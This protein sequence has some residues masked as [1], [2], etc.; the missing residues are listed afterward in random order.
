MPPSRLTFIVALVASMASISD[1]SDLSST[2]ARTAAAV[3]ISKHIEMTVSRDRVLRPAREALAAAERKKQLG[4]DGFRKGDFLVAYSEYME[5]HKALD[6]ASAE[7]TTAYAAEQLRLTVLANTAQ[8]ALK[9]NQPESAA[10][11]CRDAITL[12]A[13]CL[14]ANLFK[15]ILVRLAQA[16]TALGEHDKALAVAHEGQLRGVNCDEFFAITQKN[17]AD[18]VGALEPG[19][20]MR[21]FIMLALRMSAGPDNLERVRAVLQ[22]GKLPHVD[23]RD[24]M[25]NNM[26]WGVLNALTVE[27]SEGSPLLEDFEGGSRSIPTLA[28]LLQAG[29]DPHQRYKGGRTPLAYAA[30]SGLVDALRAVL[31]AP[32]GVGPFDDEKINAA[33]ENG[34]TA[35]HV[36]C[37]GPQKKDKKKE[38]CDDDSC[39]HSHGDAENHAD[40]DAASVVALLLS[41]GADPRVQNAEGDDALMV[42]AING[43]VGAVAALLSPPSEKNTHTGP[44]LLRNRNTYG[45]SAYVVACSAGQ[46]EVAT[47]IIA[48]A[49]AAGGEIKFEMEESAKVVKFTKLVNLVADA[50][51]DALESYFKTPGATLSQ[52]PFLFASDVFWTVETEAARTMAMLTESGFECLA[53]SGQGDTAI[54]KHDYPARA[55]ESYGDVYSALHKRVTDVTPE[56]LHK[57]YHPSNSLPSFHECCTIYWVVQGTGNLNDDIDSQKGTSPTS[58][59]TAKLVT[60][61]D[62]GLRANQ[63][64][65]AMIS[66]PLQRAFSFAVPSVEALETIVGI[67]KNIVEM[68][69][70]TGYW[71]ALL[72]ER[73]VDVMAY[74]RAPPQRPPKETDESAN[75]FFNATFTDVVRSDM[76]LSPLSGHADRALLLCW[77]VA[78][79]EQEAIGVVGED[80]WDLRCLDRW[81]GDTLIHVGE[82]RVDTLDE[83]KENTDP[84]STPPPRTTFPRGTGHCDDACG[85]TASL[86]FQTAVEERFELK[87]SVQL[88]NWWN[89]RDD[90]T[91]WVR[92]NSVSR[93]ST[94]ANIY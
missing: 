12:S 92:K 40:P 44:E 16:H 19:V 25:G 62:K 83:A 20:E 73:G 17:K 63:E 32:G 67:G 79:A 54:D 66:H 50:H 84:L 27:K 11:F 41:H 69:A 22:T 3:E 87:K 47:D 64:K 46:A 65:L 2:L 18:K 53:E 88:P 94:I 8:C 14:D 26:L 81:A 77:P 39:G 45:M 23:R 31:S 33:D 90:L 78:K 93:R 30:A 36:A 60:W 35:L 15:K 38:S 70:G 61:S 34:W 71:A 28:L 91:V 74:V 52:K 86:A 82:W 59:D 4:N 72:K 89:T 85:V 10:K 37:M 9:T 7:P 56:A 29:A 49:R 6:V 21:M 58:P 5:A 75:L 43:N 68:G 42:A 55:F 51:N 57:P 80:P 76:D 24:E 1:M 13:C 48:C